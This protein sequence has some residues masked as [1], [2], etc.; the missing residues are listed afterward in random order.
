[1]AGGKR[2]EG[3]LLRSSPSPRAQA[4]LKL[5]PGVQSARVG[6]IKAGGN[7]DREFPPTAGQ[8]GILGGGLQP[9][10]VPVQRGGTQFTPL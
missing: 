5:A 3:L 4:E 8:A 2:S 7:I 1:M 9:G 10:G 6:N